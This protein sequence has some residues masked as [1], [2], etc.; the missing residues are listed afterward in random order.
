MQKCWVN[1]I[2]AWRW[3]NV[4]LV[5]SGPLLTLQL[6]AVA[7]V[8]PLGRK[9][10]VGGISPRSSMLNPGVKSAVSF[11]HTAL[12]SVCSLQHEPLET[13]QPMVRLLAAAVIEKD[14]LFVFKP[15]EVV[16]CVLGFFLSCLMVFFLSTGPGLILFFFS[17]Y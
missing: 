1:T 4:P 3:V 9:I 8:I 12:F 6:E 16:T 2:W 14:L 5:D 10:A 13:L 7:L 15:F 11:S 17:L